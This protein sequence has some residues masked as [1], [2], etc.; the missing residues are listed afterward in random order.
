MT[1]INYWLKYASFDEIKA[2]AN[3]RG[4]LPIPLAPA[5]IYKEVSWEYVYERLPKTYM[6][7]NDT[8]V[9]TTRSYLLDIK[10]KLTSIEEIHRFLKWNLVDKDQYIADYY[11]CDNF[12]SSLWADCIRWTS[13]LAFGH[14]H[15]IGHAKDLVL[16]VDDICWDI[17]PQSD[18]TKVLN[19]PTVMYM[20]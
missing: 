19:I 2:E 1:W 4:L 10:Y 11:D 8:N 9:Y 16:C 20:M 15:T 18:V 7:P 3:R 14:F 13:G 6:L 12:A 17:E 5:K